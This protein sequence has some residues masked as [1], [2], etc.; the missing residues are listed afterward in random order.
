MLGPIIR[1]ASKL[2]KVTGINK[3]RTLTKS[4]KSIIKK[5]R[6]MGIDMPDPPKPNPNVTFKRREIK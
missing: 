3:P 4:E 2:G 1:G 5:M 6:K